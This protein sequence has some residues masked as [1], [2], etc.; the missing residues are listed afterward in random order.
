MSKNL[1]RLTKSRRSMKTSSGF[2]NSGAGWR[3]GAFL[4]AGALAGRCG[5][6]SAASGVRLSRRTPCRGA[7]G[8]LPVD[9]SGGAGDQHCR[10]LPRQV[11]GPWRHWPGNQRRNLLSV[12]LGTVGARMFPVSGHSAAQ[13]RDRWSRRLRRSAS[14][15]M[16]VARPTVAAF[17]ADQRSRLF[18]A[19]PTVA[20]FT[21]ATNGRGFFRADQRSRLCGRR[22]CPQR[23]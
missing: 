12:G 14:T 3:N 20:A 11:E 21:G 6:V 19:R 17:C 23:L 5:N 7:W 8:D 13:S 10:H 16:A 15:G 18:T 22:Y 1:R 4:V 9:P 2:Q